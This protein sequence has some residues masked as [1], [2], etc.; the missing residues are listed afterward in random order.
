MI[1]QA[2]NIIR[3][4]L[5][6]FTSLIL[7][8]ITFIISG[9]TAAQTISKIEINGAK[10]FSTKEYINWM[11][12]NSGQK[13]FPGIEESAANKI[14]ESLSS[15]GY[16]HSSTKTTAQKNDSSKIIL[17]IDINEGTPTF[18]R[19]ITVKEKLNDS[20]YV[21]QK[22]RE[23]SGSVFSSSILEHSFDII[24]TNYENNGF[25]FSNIKIATFS[26][27]DDS[28]SGKHFVDIILSIA[29]GERSRID[30]IEIEGNSKTK[31]DVIIRATRINTGELYSQKLLD[32]IPARLNRLR[33]FEP[34]EQPSFFLTNN[35]EGVL[36]ILVKEKETNNFDGIIGYVPSNSQ[37][38]NGYFTGFVNINLINLFGTGRSAQIK[39]QQ[40][41]RNSQ[42]LELHYLEP[43]LFNYP[44]NIG[45]SLFQRKQDST[46][47]QRNF[48]IN[49][50]YL[51]SEDVFASLII[52]TQSTIPSEAGQN[53]FTV[54]NSTSFTTGFKLNLDSRD[55][56]Y[57]PT[58]GVYFNSVYKFTQKNISG[59]AKFISNDM[60]TQFNQQR[61]EFDFSYFREL[62]LN[63]VGAIS[64]HAR[65]LRGSN[66]E[67]SDF[68][69]LGGTNSLRG[70][71]EKQF[72]GNRIFWSNLEY[73]YLLSRRS[74]AFLFFDTGYFLRNEDGIT[75]LPQISEFNLGYGFGLDIET[76][77][78]VLGISFA[79]GKGDSFSD[80]KI[81][82]GIKNEF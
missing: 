47:V 8:S 76:S 52:N 70:Y 64:V 9:L 21:F 39:W 48:E 62:F 37:N 45:M 6:R 14:G 2:I 1:R 3:L 61:I 68:Y 78:G 24:L 80:G 53:I 20:L 49:I 7:F 16:Y 72:A 29:E 31:P 57:A 54:Y 12:I 56:Y 10:V 34:I 58:K 75:N 50:D 82:F 33:F 42:E 69:F 13:Y 59:P 17:V 71:R 38:E 26:F 66:L 55:D 79:L 27:A 5:V 63:Q 4:F 25:P 40:E 81:H 73:R 32:Q 74:Y 30:K 28:I 51:A 35:N 36:K 44:F 41:N 22:L 77:L 60:Q 65:E 11:G 15:E 43:W 18:I 23:L 19:N 46:Y 67:L